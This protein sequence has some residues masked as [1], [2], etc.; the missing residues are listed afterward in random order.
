MLITILIVISVILIGG[1]IFLN[2][3]QFGRSPRG[4]R[5]E[6]IKKSPNYKDGEFVNREETRVVTSEQ[7]RLAAMWDFLFGKKERVT[8]GDAIPAVKTDLKNLPADKDWLVWFGHSSNLMNINGKKILVDPV[9]YAASPVSFVNRPFKG[10]DLYRPDDLPD[11]DYYIISHDHWDHLDAKTVK[12]LDARVG[13]FVCPLGVGEHLERWGVNPSKI[14]ELDWDESVSPEPGLT[15]NCLTSRHFTGRGLS[16]NKTLWASYMLETSHG[17]VFIGGDGGY[18]KHFKE[19]G[20]KYPKIDLA[21]LENGQYDKDWAQIHTLPEELTKVASDL[22]PKEIL[23]VHHS[24]FALAKHPWDD[25]IKTAHKL[26]DQYNFNVLIPHIG[27]P[28]FLDL[29]SDE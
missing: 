13:R 27:A 9:F 10:T 4:E 15:I 6:R 22:N 17:N 11:I 12:E 18:G 25:P 5:L 21:V 28:V 7:N 3:P 19:I 16:S 24:K 26:R 29:S 20:L 8:P 2:L 14:L 1:I 23:T